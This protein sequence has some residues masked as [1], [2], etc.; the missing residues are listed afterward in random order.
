MA[1]LGYVNG[2]PSDYSCGGSLVSPQFVL[3]AAHCL[4]PRGYGAVK[5]VKLGATSRNQNNSNT[6]N[7]VEIFQHPNFEPKKLNNDLGLL[8]LESAV[9]MS[10]RIMPI[11][12]PQKLHLPEKAV[13]SGFGKT[14]FAEDSSTVLLKITLEK[15]TQADCQRPFGT[16]VT[17][18]NDSMIC[19]GHRTEKKDSCGGDSGERKVHNNVFKIYSLHSTSQVVHCNFTTLNLIALTLKSAS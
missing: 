19:Y 1:H 3:T 18:T 4:Y 6:V 13:A 15:F 16:S 17:V 8:K 14:G 11:C 7:V 12:L 10:E 5:F 9:P 2:D